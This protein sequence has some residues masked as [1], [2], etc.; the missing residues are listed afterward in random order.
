MRKS[1]YVAVVF[2]FLAACVSSPIMPVDGSVPPNT[3]VKKVESAISKGAM[4]KGWVPKTL[5]GNIMELTLMAR[6]HRVVVDVKYSA[7]NYIISYKD[8]TNMHYDPARNSIHPKYGKWLANLK[9]S[10][11]RNLMMTANARP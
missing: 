7:T 6:E 1:F 8:S 4:E 11:E 5:G 3:D 10:I 2:L 9:Q